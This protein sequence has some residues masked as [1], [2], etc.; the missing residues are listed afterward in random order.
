MTDRVE[1]ITKKIPCDP[2]LFSAFKKRK[3]GPKSYGDG[4]IGRNSNG[5][6]GANE[7]L[8]VAGQRPLP[9]CEWGTGRLSDFCTIQLCSYDHCGSV[10]LFYLCNYQIAVS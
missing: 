4:K 5:P 8:K 1:V 3:G 6:D 7:L 9:I 10:S 2:C